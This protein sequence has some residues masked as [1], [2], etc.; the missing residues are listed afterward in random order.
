MPL[1]LVDVRDLATAEK[2][3]IAGAVSIPATEI[4]NAKAWFPADKKAPVILYAADT[5]AAG[6]AFET[7]RGWG[8]KNSSI[9]NG[10]FAAWQ[11]A[12]LPTVSKSLL[13]EINY[14]AK[15]PPGVIK[16]ADFIA[17]A[18][19]QPADK[20]L[21]DVREDYEAEEGMLKGARNI[22]TAEIADRLAELPKDKE[23]VCYCNTGVRAEMAYLT[24]MENGYTARYLLAN[25]T[26]KPDGGYEITESD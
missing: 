16:I 24:L 5:K 3:H 17:V 9:M 6:K 26:V 15:M 22:P 21:L 4:D 20:V 23:I 11:K 2:A 25:L 12:N 19:T 13:A 8:Y 14:V 18:D 7:V 10:G 1:V